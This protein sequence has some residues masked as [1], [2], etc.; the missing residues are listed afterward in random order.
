M[1]NQCQYFLLIKLKNVWA[2][3]DQKRPCKIKNQVDIAWY[4]KKKD[5]E[6]V[7]AFLRRLDAK[8]NSAKG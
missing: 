7:F 6:R 8:H 5:L 4:Q 1:G 3:I 2:K